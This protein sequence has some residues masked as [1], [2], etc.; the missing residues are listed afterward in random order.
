MW[1]PTRYRSQ[2]LL[3]VSHDASVT[4]YPLKTKVYAHQQKESYYLF[5]N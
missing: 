2:F 4:A 3:D 1:F 5:I